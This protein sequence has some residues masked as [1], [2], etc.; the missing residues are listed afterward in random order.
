MKFK[1]LLCILSILIMLTGCSA[2][3]FPEEEKE[4]TWANSG[5]IT[6]GHCLTIQNKDNQF[7]LLDNI[8]VLSAEGLYYATWAT[9]SREPYV[10]SEGD[11]VDLYDAHLYLLLG[12]YP[13]SNKAQN[14][15]NKWLD[16]G[17]TNYEIL[18]EEDTVCNGQTYHLI[19]YNC[20][21]EDNPYDRGISAFGVC[22]DNAVCI[23]LTCLENFG[24]D[25]RT[26]MINFLNN[27]T[28]SAGTASF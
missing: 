10:N 12:E 6:I 5:S 22:H 18:K 16:T 9:G 21:S 8:D 24:Q 14:N 28:Y 4:D 17:K 7:S 19:T 27:C 26:I 13:D 1:F 15:M 11:T 20:I 23:E 3:L 2:S 25:L